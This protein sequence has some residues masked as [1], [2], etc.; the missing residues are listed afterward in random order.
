MSAFYISGP[1]AF[2]YHFV[3]LWGIPPFYHPFDDTDTVMSALRCLRQGVDVIAANP[4]DPEARPFDYSP[5]WLA[6]AV[7]PVTPAWLNGA[8]LLVDFGFFA[9]LLLLPVARDGRAALALALAAVSSCAVLAV[10]R[11]NNDLVLFV[12]AALAAV[13]LGRAWGVRIIGYG[14]LL[15]AGLLKY[16]PMAAMAV[17]LREKVGRFVFLT[18]ASLAITGLFVAITWHDLSRALAIIP[19][20][21]PFGNMF[22][23]VNLGAGIA[24]DGHLPPVW[25]YAIR[26]ALTGFAVFWATKRAGE[27]ATRAALATL[28]ARETHFLMV[29]ALLVVAAFFTAQNIGYRVI[30]LLLVLPALLALRHAGP[31]ARFRHAPKVALLLMWSELWRN[32]ARWLGWHLGGKIG[33]GV[34]KYLAFAAKEAMWWW[35]V[36]VLASYVLAWLSQGP[37]CQMAHRLLGGKAA[38]EG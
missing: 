31:A 12:L 17:A 1:L 32:R 13:A 20:G 2:Y 33:L 34:G 23:A 4:C 16:Y 7:L 9:S 5:L 8:G 10:E 3:R 11:G 6:L 26:L 28:S 38:A 14:L 19:E 27:P 35:L 15:L 25:P 36:I 29:G 37:L 30:H 18:L 22:G 21:T 24:L